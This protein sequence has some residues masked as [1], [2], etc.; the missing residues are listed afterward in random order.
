PSDQHGEQTRADA[1]RGEP[2]EEDDF[3]V[4]A[5]FE[6]LGTR[7]DAHQTVGKDQIEDGAR[8]SGHRCGDP[9]TGVPAHGHPYVVLAAL[10]R[11]NVLT[12]ARTDRALW[13]EH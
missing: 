4:G 12:E 3:D 2:S 13:F 9:L 1:Q 7:R 5:G 10:L 6:S 8:L 11:R